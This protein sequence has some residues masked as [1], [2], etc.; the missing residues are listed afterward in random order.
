MIEHACPTFRSFLAK[1]RAYDAG[2]GFTSDWHRHDDA[3]FQ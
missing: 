3:L 1:K 2:N